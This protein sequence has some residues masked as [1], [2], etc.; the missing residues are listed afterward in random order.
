MAHGD[1]TRLFRGQGKLYFAE[2]VGG[3]PTGFEFAGNVKELM[4]EPSVET[5]EHR[6]TQTGNNSIDKVIET[7]LGVKISATFESF[8]RKN[9]QRMIYGQIIDTEAGVITAESQTAYLGKSISLENINAQTIDSI[10][11]V[12]GATTYT[13]GVD[14]EIEN[15]PA[16]MICILDGGTITEGQELEVN[17]TIGESEQ[18][19]AFTGVNKEYFLRFNGLNDAESRNPVVIEIPKARFEPVGDI[20][21]IN[22]DFAEYKVSGNALFDS[23]QPVGK[24]QYFDIKQLKANLAEAC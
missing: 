21:L 14:Y 8:E 22:D 9:L 15:L 6:E 23:C 11:D 12:G 20:P 13:E 1:N 3:K 4:L 5:K 10:T 18:I 24:S 2:R 17:Y 7:S 16:S 19:G